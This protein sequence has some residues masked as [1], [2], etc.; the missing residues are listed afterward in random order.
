[1]KIGLS[2]T[3]SPIK[4]QH[5]VDWLAQEGD[6]DIF[7]LDPEKDNASE[8]RT[9]DGLV[10]AGGIDVNPKLYNGNSDYANKPEKWN[11]KR[12]A[13]ETEL[14]LIAK[15]LR[16][17][18]LAICRGM[19]LVNVLEGGTLRPDLG[20]LNITHYK[21]AD[22]DSQHRVEVLLGSQ[23]RKI[24]EIE[25]GEI[26]SAHHQC[27]DTLGEGLIGN[28]LASDETI[29]GI[30]WENTQERGFFIGVQWHPERMVLLGLGES[31]M[32][33][34]IRERFVEEVSVHESKS[35]QNQHAY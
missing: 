25:A 26:N 17:P 20:K 33:T 9:C 22:G 5:Y 35:K 23:L 21:T 11:E 15:E 30:E 28:C 14:Y 12:D 18:V 3:G 8:L 24:L 31:R 16:M 13:F 29:E 4:H 7:T 1:M 34:A 27:V 19:H 32:A 2:Y 10:L 6:A